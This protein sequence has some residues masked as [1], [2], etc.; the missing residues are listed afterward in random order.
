MN[1]LIVQERNNRRE[2]SFWSLV[3]KKDEKSCWEW[4]GSKRVGYGYFSGFGVNMPAHRF[5]YLLH[6]KSI[7][8]RIGSRRAVVR[9]LCENRG[10]VNPNHLRIGTDHD[11]LNDYFTF[12]NG[13]NLKFTSEEIE[14]IRFVRESPLILHMLK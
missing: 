1:P 11:N 4:L 2:S 10:C 3:D 13:K 6:N 14:K 7:P 9:H 12:K 8:K 5:S